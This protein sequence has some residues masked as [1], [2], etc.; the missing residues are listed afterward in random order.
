MS[1]N[2]SIDLTASTVNQ[3]RHCLSEWN[4]AHTT[5]QAA[6]EAWRK[7]DTDLKACKAYYTAELTKDSTLKNA[8]QR[9]ARLHE[10]LT[11]EARE[12]LDTESNAARIRRDAGATLERL[13]E[14]LKTLRCIANAEGSERDAQTAHQQAEAF[15]KLPF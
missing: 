10:V 4:R 8:E 3:L 2:G 11:L 15:A 6:D 7:L 5:Y 12:L 9:T 1:M 13:T 14:T